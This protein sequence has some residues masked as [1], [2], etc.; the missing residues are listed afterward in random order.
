MIT[1]P[2]PTLPTNN[3]SHKH[4]DGS[5]CQKCDARRR[6]WQHRNMC[7]CGEKFFHREGFKKHIYDMKTKKAKVATTILHLNFSNKGQIPLPSVLNI[8]S[9]MG[10]KISPSSLTQLYQTL[11]DSLENAKHFTQLMMK[12]FVISSRSMTGSEILIYLHSSEPQHDDP[13]E[14][15]EDDEIEPELPLEK[16]KPCKCSTGNC[17]GCACKRAFKQCS[18]TCSCHPTTCKNRGK[19]EFEQWVKVPLFPSQ[20]ISNQDCGPRNLTSRSKEDPAA[21]FEQVVRYVS[22]RLSPLRLWNLFGRRYLNHATIG[23]R[24]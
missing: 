4:F 5:E 17:S 18:D 9:Q 11:K 1:S 19:D 21:C 8:Y 3:L 6:C 2:V 16:A 24:M 7:S 22:F 14:E 15:E 20:P 10:N 23:P 12:I 13:A